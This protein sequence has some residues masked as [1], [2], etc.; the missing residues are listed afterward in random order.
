MVDIMELAGHH[1]STLAHIL[2]V[3]R[4]N[5]L[6]DFVQVAGPLGVTHF[7]MLSRTEE[8]INLRVCRL[9]RGPTITF[10]IKSVSTYEGKGIVHQCSSL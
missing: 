10:H 2:Q 5:V 9:P 7:L 4:K 3:H 6:K 1:P 8:F